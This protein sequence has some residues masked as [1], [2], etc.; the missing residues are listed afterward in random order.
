MGLKDGF[1]ILIL[2]PAMDALSFKRNMKIFFITREKVC[3]DSIAI[4]LFPAELETEGAIGLRDE[5]YD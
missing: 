3:K 5:I 1:L 2:R 4:T